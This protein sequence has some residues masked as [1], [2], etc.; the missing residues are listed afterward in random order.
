MSVKLNRAIHRKITQI[1]G[2]RALATK[3][4]A[5]NTGKDADNKRIV[6]IIGAVA[7]RCNQAERNVCSRRSPTHAEL[8]P[9]KRVHG[10]AA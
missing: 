8:S 3:V 4:T 5:H 1:P 2:A 10:S 7:N 9:E 6:G